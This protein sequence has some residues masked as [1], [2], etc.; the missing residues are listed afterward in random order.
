[1]QSIIIILLIVGIVM[2][3]DGIYREEIMKLKEEK[4]IE[5]KFI[6]RSMYEDALY[7]NNLKQNYE[8]IFTEKH[9]TRSA[10][11]FE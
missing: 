9:D 4:K 6:P 11:R 5:Y 7:S 2:V 3:I 1:M 8:H 10:G